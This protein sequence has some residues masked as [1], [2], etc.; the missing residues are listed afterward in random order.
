MAGPISPR[1]FDEGARTGIAAQNPGRALPIG[2]GYAHINMPKGPNR[3]IEHRGKW[4]IR[5]TDENGR[6]RSEVHDDRAGA[7]LALKR[8]QLEVAE[9]A[10]GLRPAAIGDQRFEELCAEWPATRTAKTRSKRDDESMIRV[11]LSLLRAMMRHAVDI[12]WLAIAPKIKLYR[13][14]V[15]TANFR[16]L[17]TAEEVRRFLGRRS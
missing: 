9:R 1:S 2:R 6:R 11:H 8:H 3:P 5:W 13:V 16:F 7:K 4:R 15:V 14:A 12:G 17:R 10:A